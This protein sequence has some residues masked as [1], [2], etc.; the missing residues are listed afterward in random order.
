MKKAPVMS[1]RSLL[2]ALTAGAGNLNLD[3][4]LGL[5]LAI[6]ANLDWL[7]AGQTRALS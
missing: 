6:G 5:N 1:V 2:L 7:A 3:N 4:V